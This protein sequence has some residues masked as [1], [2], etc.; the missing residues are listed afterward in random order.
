MRRV[1]STPRADWQARLESQGFAFHTIDGQPYWREDICYVFDE[2]QIDELEAATNELHSLCLDAVDRVVRGGRYADLGLDERAATLI[3]R[4]WWDR[5]PA[6]YGRMD[7]SYDGL[8]PPRLLEYNADTPTALF[9][10]S[11]AQWYWL[12]DVASDADQFNSIHEALVERWRTLPPASHVHFAACYD[13]TEDALTCDYLVDTCMQAGH[14]A[15][16]LDV[17][18]IGWS[19]KDFIDLENAPIERLFKLYPWEW[20]LSEPFAAHLPQTRLRWF[21]PAWKMVLSNKAI[22][23]LLWEFFP[24][25][26]NLLPASRRR[27]DVAG[28]VVR[29]PYW[30]REGAGV[31]VLE[32][33]QDEGSV[34]ESCI[35]QAL[36]P[37][38]VFDGRHALVGSWV[39]GSNAVGIGMREDADRITRNTSCFVP[40]LFR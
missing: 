35:Y 33:G 29:K 7:L 36:A 20:M 5:E 37:L 31:T 2:A 27:A 24:G 21:E 17:E 28:A 8:S 12:Q 26:P 10:A 9:E 1:T 22:L 39:V 19:G 38:P 4:S 23:P 6:L 13:S 14:R 3:E 40:H 25:H 18:Q 15:T 30:G 16:A 32:P 11:V 34:T